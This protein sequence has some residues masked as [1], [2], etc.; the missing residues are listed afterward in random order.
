[1][2]MEEKNKMSQRNTGITL[3][4]LVITIIIML[5]LVGITIN[6]TIGE[7]GII[8]KAQEAGK[9]MLLAQEQEKEELNKLYSSMQIATNDDSQITISIQDLNK[10]IDEK[11]QAKAQEIKEEL[12]NASAISYDNTESKL[13]STNVQD[14]VDELNQNLNST[15]NSIN[16]IRNALETKYAVFENVTINSN[17]YTILYI[18]PSVNKKIIGVSGW[19]LNCAEAHVADA[20]PVGDGRWRI[21]VTNPKTDQ[22]TITIAIYYLEI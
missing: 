4:T 14:T 17:G 2:S 20:N 3:I 1:M 12:G 10:I 18:N 22:L 21:V 8:T 5:I 13:E 19:N 11:V 15:N 16:T 9:N 6:L 7:G